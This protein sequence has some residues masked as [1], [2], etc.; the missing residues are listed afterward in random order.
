MITEQIHSVTIT[1]IDIP[2]ISAY[3]YTINR[4]NF[5]DTAN[6]F[7]EQGILIPPFEEPIINQGAIAT[8][9]EQEAK[10]MQLQPQQA[11]SQTL[12]SGEIRVEVTGKVK[13]PLF[14]VNVAWTFTLTSENK[15]AQVKVKLLGSLPELLNLRSR[16]A[17]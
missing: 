14:I 17:N 13:T 1:G 10:G 11:K 5:Q 6:L 2:V 3:F 12:D 15:I 16:S 7:T 9:L 8:Y 4:G